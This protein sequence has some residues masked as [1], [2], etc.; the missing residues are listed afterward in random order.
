[1][2]Y[3]A[4]PSDPFSLVNHPLQPLLQ[5][6]H[7]WTAPLLVFAAGLIWRSHVWE[8]WKRRLPQGRRT[9]IVLMLTLAPM[10]LSGIL[11]QTTVSDAWRRTWVVVHLA[12]A[13]A[14]ISSHAIHAWAKWRRERRRAGGRSSRLTSPLG[15]P[16]EPSSRAA[17]RRRRSAA[18]LG[19][20]S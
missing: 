2:R 5:H 1:M 13:V 16:A 12:T 20:A 19:R 18:T 14:W 4:T 15:A 8:H 11:I 7:L 10:T 9:G 3:F 17:S 6:L